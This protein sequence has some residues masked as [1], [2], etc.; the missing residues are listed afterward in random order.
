MHI[1]AIEPLGVTDEKLM[2]IAAPLV[3][4]GHT[5]VQ[6][7]ER[8]D[9]LPELI[10]RSRKADVLLVVDQILP[11]K[12]F[13]ACPN[14]KMISVASGFRGQVDLNKARAKLVSVYEMTE[15]WTYSVAEFALGLTLAVMRG[16]VTGDAAA[17]GG[18]E[19]VIARGHELFGKTA[20][21]IGT[22]LS[23]AHFAGILK[24]FGCELLGCRLDHE[25][26]ADV[27][28]LKYVTL[29]ELLGRS[30]VVSLHL[31]LNPDSEGFLNRD[32]IALMKQG[33]ILIN[34]AHEGL[35]DNKGLSEALA[36]GR[37]SGAGV[38]L[39]VPGAGIPKSHPLAKAPNMV[40]APSLGSATAEALEKRAGIALGNVAAWMGGSPG[41]V[42]A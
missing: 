17:R 26:G 22:D 11:G 14:I 39:S 34:T 19:Q 29:D 32:K 25:K 12:L 38:D 6:H 42:M 15:Y 21:I 37:L 23:G 40:L 30:D 2:E 3:G 9:E 33:S 10:Q 5:V 20:G 24:A 7:S 27:Q 35:V 28:G 13:E 41:G 31:P 1:V 8:T 36:D 18:K 4:K 16:I